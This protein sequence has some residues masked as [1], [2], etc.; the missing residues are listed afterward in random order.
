VSS[1]VTNPAVHVY[2][3]A[4]T[5]EGLR[6]QEDPFP[7]QTIL[8]TVYESTAKMKGPYP[9]WDK[10]IHF[11]VSTDFFKTK[12]RNIVPC[13]NQFEVRIGL[14]LVSLLSF[15]HAAAQDACQ[16]GDGVT[17]CCPCSA[18]S[19]LLGFVSQIIND[20]IYLAAPSDCPLYADGT[21]RKGA[22]SSGGG[23]ARTVSLLVSEDE[24]LSF[25]EACVPMK[26]LDKGYNLFETHGGDGAFLIVSDVLCA[27]SMPC[28][29]MPICCHSALWSPLTY[30]LCT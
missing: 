10:D 6:L 5:V 14:S 8:A 7:D 24:G 20:Q 13:G 30:N 28:F 23:R 12:P 4:L 1:S 22:G 21:K 17:H 19:Q 25:S 29:I 26:W 11:L 9:G 16:S 27:V 2:S 3:C 15:L 18:T